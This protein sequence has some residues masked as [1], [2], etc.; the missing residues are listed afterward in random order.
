MTTALHDFI[1]LMVP[2]K[3]SLFLR[4][5][6]YNALTLVKSSWKWISEVPFLLLKLHYV[7]R[8]HVT[9]ILIFQSIIVNKNLDRILNVFSICIRV[10]YKKQGAEKWL[11]PLI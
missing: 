7:A 9:H 10:S 11:I 1:K 2:F 4:L 5:H 3:I 8:V 6:K